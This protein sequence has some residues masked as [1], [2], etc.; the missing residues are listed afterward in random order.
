MDRRDV[1]WVTPKDER[2]IGPNHRMVEAEENHDESRA[3]FHAPGEVCAKKAKP[4]LR[5]G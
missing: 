4:F 1:W 2:T 3:L 5:R